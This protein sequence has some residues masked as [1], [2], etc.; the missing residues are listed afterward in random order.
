[1]VC[2]HKLVALLPSPFH[3]FPPCTLSMLSRN[4]KC[5]SILQKNSTV[6]I[7]LPNIAPSLLLQ[8]GKK[9]IKVCRQNRRPFILQKH[10]K[11]IELFQQNHLLWKAHI[12]LRVFSGFIKISL[13]YVPISGVQHNDL[14]YIYQEMMTA[15]SLV[16]IYY[17]I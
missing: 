2:L 12:V 11:L 15:I 14:T 16:N 3:L 4:S 17:L 8:I 9:K 7:L 10:K 13:T 6:P 1:M 5:F